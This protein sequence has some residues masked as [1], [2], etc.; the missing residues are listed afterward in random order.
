MSNFRRKILVLWALSMAVTLFC[1]SFGHAENDESLFGI[2]LSAGMVGG[3]QGAGNPLPAL[4]GHAYRLGYNDDRY[5]DYDLD[6]GFRG[7]IRGFVGQS[8]QDF[9][10]SQVAG[11]VQ[12]R[13]GLGVI[14]KKF[15]GLVVADI[16]YD[17][18]MDK[19]KTGRE[20]TIAFSGVEIGPRMRSENHLVFIGV[21][22][23]IS[24][25]DAYAYAP[26]EKS[27]STAIHGLRKAIGVSVDG[28]IGG[29]GQKGAV[30]L[31][32][33][34]TVMEGRGYRTDAAV[35]V[36]VSEALQV[37]A[38]VRQVHLDQKGQKPFSLTTPMLR[39]T[40]GGW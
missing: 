27:A 6:W 31:H 24:G 17:G 5:P 29:L 30:A 4:G 40:V 28:R 33:T 15:Y 34:G 19:N 35:D 32:G 22:A 38:E 9:P 2:G 11:A 20:T 1:S 14:M 36:T 8:G 7:A 18:V 21:Q 39:L 25:M 23:G 10:R 3:P 13:G 16:N 12:A 26:G 37:G